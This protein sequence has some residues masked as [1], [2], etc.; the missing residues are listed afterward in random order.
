MRGS[1]GA[2][3]S[4]EEG[5]SLRLVFLGPPGA[6]KGTHAARAAEQW[7]IAHISTG[8]LFRAEAKRDTPLGRKLAGYMQQ[9]VLVPDEVVIELVLARLEAGDAR[10]GF[11]LDGF[12]RTVSQAEALDRALDATH[13]PIELV[14]HFATSQAVVVRRLS[15]RRICR[16]CGANFNV[17]TLRPRQAGR[18]D[19]C[20]GELYQ[21]VDDLPE[22]VLTRL[23]VYEQESAPVVDY[24]RRR[25]LLRDVNGDVELAEMAEI[26]T[27][28]V[29]DERLLNAP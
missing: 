19:R 5:S 28:L 22:T 1:C 2:A 27:R 3:T 6:G 21:R 13:L 17:D 26:L 11:T 7:G 8:D 4:A 29:T 20:G 15:G 12:P 14:I 9:G 16:A 23:S 24:Y 25:G 10:Q 18:C